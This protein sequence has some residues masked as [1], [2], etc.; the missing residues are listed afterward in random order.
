MRSVREMID[1][2]RF[3]E[4][5]ADTPVGVVDQKRAK[6]ILMRSGFL[7]SGGEFNPEYADLVLNE[8]LTVTNLPIFDIMRY[9]LKEIFWLTKP[10]PQRRI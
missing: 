8:K 2:Q 10:Q 1:A 9:S 4:K 5:Y 3:L 6:E 7:T